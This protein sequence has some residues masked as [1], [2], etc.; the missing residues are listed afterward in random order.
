MITSGGYERY[1]EDPETGKIYRHILDPRTGSPAESCL[2]SV[3]IV[4]SDGTLGD[5][6]STALYILGLA[7]ATQFWRSHAEEFDAIFITDDGTLYATEGL[8]GSIQSEHEIR[9][10]PK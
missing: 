8:R 4:T 3:S 7:D 5:G 2:S 1:F 6:L 10:I 9:F